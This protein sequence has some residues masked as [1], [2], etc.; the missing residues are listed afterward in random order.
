MQHFH[1]KHH[2]YIIIRSL[3]CVCVSFYSLLIESVSFT[4]ATATELSRSFC[5]LCFFSFCPLL[6]SC[7]C[8][9]ACVWRVI[10]CVIFSVI[11]SVRQR[12]YFLA[13]YLFTF[14]SSFYL[15][16]NNM[17]TFW[18]RENPSEYVMSLSLV[19]INIFWKFL[20][21]VPFV[22]LGEFTIYGVVSLHIST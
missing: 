17:N 22:V 21:P 14:M 12:S 5:S 3:V 8:V 4:C 7:L 16:T 1:N 9:R 20:L 6:S 13:V 18:K 2:I 19:V 11:R 10:V 15:D